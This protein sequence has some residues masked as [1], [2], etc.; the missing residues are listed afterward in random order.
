VIE[1]RVA[2]GRIVGL[3]V[4]GDAARIDELEIVLLDQ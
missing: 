1:F 3:D 4:T 2:D